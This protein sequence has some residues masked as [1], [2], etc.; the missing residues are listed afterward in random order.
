VK[1]WRTTTLGMAAI[2]LG[3]WVMRVTYV[4]SNTLYFN[5]VYVWP[6]AWALIISGI[7]LVNARDHK[8]KGD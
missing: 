6:G 4:P 2:L 7:G 8:Y 5:I 1:S 3:L